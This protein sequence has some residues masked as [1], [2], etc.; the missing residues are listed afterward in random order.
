V[1]LKRYATVT[2]CRFRQPDGVA[3]MLMG[4]VI[5]NVEEGRSYTTINVG[6]ELRSALHGVGDYLRR[7]SFFYLALMR[8]PSG[9]EMSRTRSR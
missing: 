5:N 9:A 1:S 7:R 6:E 4:S 3:I 8:L 2:K